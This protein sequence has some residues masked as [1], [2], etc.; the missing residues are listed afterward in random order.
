[1]WVDLISQHLNLRDM[2]QTNG[3]YIKLLFIDQT[4]VIV[5]AKVQNTPDKNHQKYITN[6]H[7]QHIPIKVIWHITR[8]EG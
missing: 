1:M 6:R 3:L 2:R 8:N 4:K 5:D 7:K